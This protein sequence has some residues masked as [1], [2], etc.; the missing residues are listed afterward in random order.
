MKNMYKLYASGRIEID[1]L[2]QVKMSYL[3]HLK[4]VN[5]C[6]LISKTLNRYEKDFYDCYEELLELNSKIARIE[7][8]GTVVIYINGIFIRYRNNKKMKNSIAFKLVKC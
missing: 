1:K 7:D 8:D 3:G 4:Y 2:I 6:N 5:S